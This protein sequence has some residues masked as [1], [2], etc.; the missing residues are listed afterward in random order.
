MKPLLQQGSTEQDA[1]RDLQASLNKA[2]NP[3]P[4]LTVDGDFGPATHAAVKSFQTQASLTIDGVVGKYTWSALMLACQVASQVQQTAQSQQDSNTAQKALADI[5][6]N[7]LGARE[8]GNNLAGDDMR[9][10]EIFAADT[11]PGD[12][13]PWCA[14]FVSLCVQKLLDDNGNY[15]HVHAPREASVHRFLT[16]WAEANDC[17]VF[18]PDN[19]AHTPNRGDIVVFTFSH[20]GIVDAVNDDGVVTIEGN[21]NEAGSREGI[22]VAEKQRSMNVIKRFIRLPIAANQ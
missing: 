4:N 16:Q 10:M 9:M 5:A 2:V 17:L 15:Q 6:R 20:I 8:T 11:I 21:T 14:A 1:V 12:G 22:M 7:Y 18:E 3:S 13:Y 19:Q